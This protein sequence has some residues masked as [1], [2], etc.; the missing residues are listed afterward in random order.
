LGAI[1]I[2]LLGKNVMGTSM[3]WTHILINVFLLNGLVPGAANNL[4][5]RGGWYVGTS[6]IFYLLMPILYRIYNCKID[7]W[8]KIRIWC[9][10]LVITIVSS[11]AV[12]IASG[13]DSRF[14][15]GNNSFIYFSFVNQLPSFAMGYTL[16]DWKVNNRKY[17]KWCL[18]LLCV[19]FGAV[20]VVLFFSNLNHAFVFVPTVFSMF[21]CV[22]F[23]LLSE[24]IEKISTKTKIMQRWGE[25]SYAIY[26]THSL[27]VYECS[28][29]VIRLWEFVFNDTLQIFCFVIWVPIAYAIVYYV[30]RI[31][32]WYLNHITQLLKNKGELNGHKT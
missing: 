6:I 21:F 9:F 5:V 27:I 7:S 15:C 32:T 8:R 18:L 1:S 20:S 25:Y 30:S 31:F 23:I 10:P 22:L 11:V 29:I 12:I 28:V 24:K 19:F 13:I 2:I 26:L 16:Y 4:V 14:Y 17:N 3:N